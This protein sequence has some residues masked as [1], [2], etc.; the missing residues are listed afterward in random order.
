MYFDIILTDIVDIL[1]RCLFGSVLQDIKYQIMSLLNCEEKS[2]DHLRCTIASDINEYFSNWILA[3]SV[4]I[5]IILEIKTVI[6]SVLASL[7]SLLIDILSILRIYIIRVYR[8][9]ISE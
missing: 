8:P 7:R 6:W 9:K 2:I 1:F 4:I 5:P 3:K